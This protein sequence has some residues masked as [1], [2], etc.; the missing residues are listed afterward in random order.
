LHFKV[1]PVG[2]ESLSP[3]LSIYIKTNL[4]GVQIHPRRP[5]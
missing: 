4:I 1:V 3:Y 2:L 5:F